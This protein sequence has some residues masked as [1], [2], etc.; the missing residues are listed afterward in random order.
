MLKDAKA[1]PQYL[2][3]NK[4]IHVLTSRYF[5]Y[6]L[7]DNLRT[8]WSTLYIVTSSYKY[9]ASITR[10]QIVNNYL[11]R[12]ESFSK[13]LRSLRYFTDTKFALINY[14]KVVRYE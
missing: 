8:N 7:V 2:W 14:K 13:F 3:I 4:V 9:L 12:L 11:L 6:Y 5:T 10:Q 1:Y